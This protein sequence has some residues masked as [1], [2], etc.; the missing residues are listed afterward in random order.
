MTPS[1]DEAEK[2]KPCPFC[3]GIKLSVCKTP[4]MDS[5]AYTVTCLTVD[6]NGAIFSLGYGRFK[7]KQEAISGWNTRTSDPKPPSTALAG[8]RP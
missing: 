5:D 3:G 2:L 8:A 7:T 6:C 4:Y 1:S